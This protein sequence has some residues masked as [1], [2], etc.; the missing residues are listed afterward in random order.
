MIKFFRHI[1]QNLIMKNQTG[2]YFK[3][4]IGEIILVVIGILIALQI[5]NWNENQKLEVQEYAIIQSF[6][7]EIKNNNQVLIESIKKN[8]YINKVS[9]QVLDSIDLGISIFERQNILITTNYNPKSFDLS[10][11]QNI[12]NNQ[13]RLLTQKEALIAKLRRLRFLHESIVKSLYYLDENWNKQSSVFIINC[14]FNLRADTIN[15]NKISLNQLEDCRYDVDKLKALIS[16]TYELRE[17]WIQNMESTLNHSES[18]LKELS[19]Y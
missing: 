2:K 9:A 15:G 4:A 11:L 8:R 13:S 17:D 7:D 19:N 16:L 3:Y 14:G 5:N 18:L 6:T 1:R 12:L 10:V